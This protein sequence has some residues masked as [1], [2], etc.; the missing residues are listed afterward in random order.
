M[1]NSTP[2]WNPQVSL[3][4]ESPTN[5]KPNIKSKDENRKQS[6][7]LRNYTA[8]TGYD[9][10]MISFPV[11]NLDLN[12]TDISFQRE[13]SLLLRMMTQFMHTSLDT[14]QLQQV[15]KY[16]TNLVQGKDIEMFQ[17]NLP[18]RTIQT[19][20]LKGRLTRER[21]SSGFKYEGE[22]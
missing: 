9:R 13:R 17:S 3:R 10:D 15:F 20:K 18:I 1:T 2:P 21:I 6:H 16:A 22:E 11:S 7:N 5:F 8:S 4:F 14:N 19:Q 12:V